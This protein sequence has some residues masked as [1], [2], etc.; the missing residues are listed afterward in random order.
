M[1][2]LELKE[3]QSV[4]YQIF[5]KALLNNS[6]SQ[7]Y[8]FVGDYGTPMLETAI[9]LAQS[10]LCEHCDENGFACGHCDVCRRVAEGNFSDLMI[11]DGS[12]ASIK[13]EM[14]LGIRDKFSKTALET[15]G[16][17]VYIVNACD[18]ATPEALN[19]LLKFLEEPTNDVYAILITNRIESL[20]DTIISRVQNI[21]FKPLSIS[22]C[23]T[24]CL[25]LGIEREDAEIVSRIV[26]NPKMVNDITLQSSYIVI[27]SFV[28]EFI[29]LFIES[30]DLA[31]IELQQFIKNNKNYGKSEYVLF[32]DF[33]I[34]YFKECIAKSFQGNDIW[35]DL[36]NRG[37]N[38][39]CQLFMRVL[40]E[41]KDEFQRYPNASLMF[42]RIMY[43][44]KKGV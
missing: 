12:E 2:A 18:N 19:S 25:E 16:K 6:I 35:D 13:K 9:L 44:L 14:I 24:Q 27:K 17:K 40:L 10:L 39:D 3:T 32:I 41:S 20:L 22:Q 31:A 42:D 28:L 11:L 1:N 36:V 43:R 26:K 23:V 4:V 5:S 29:G 21:K 37:D 7:G 15:Y 30:P 33:L 8:L 38:L 34:V